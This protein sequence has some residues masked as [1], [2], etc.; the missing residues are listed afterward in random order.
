M[1]QRRRADNAPLAP[2]TRSE[3]DAENNDTGFEVHPAQASI[4]QPNQ[5]DIANF[6]AW[7][8]S[9]E[10][11]EY[12]CTAAS[13]QI[14]L[15]TENLAILVRVKRAR[16]ARPSRRAAGA[17]LPAAKLCANSRNWTELECA[18]GLFHRY[19]LV[20]IVGRPV[21]P[22]RP[23]QC[24]LSLSDIRLPPARTELNLANISRA[25]RWLRLDIIRCHHFQS[26]C[27]SMRMSRI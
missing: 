24:T 16:L 9:S 18:S 2:F 27:P 23:T 12:F 6:R 7:L 21:L 11:S 10:S 3:V 17:V 15:E 26:Q 4:A 1:G 25:T 22:S 5:K 19:S 14:G 8:R 13:G 20:T